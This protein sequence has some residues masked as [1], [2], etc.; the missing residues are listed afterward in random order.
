MVFIYHG[1][2]DVYGM[3]RYGSN[4]LGFADKLKGLFG[5]DVKDVGCNRGFLFFI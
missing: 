2:A 4:V 3:S 1:G 5:F